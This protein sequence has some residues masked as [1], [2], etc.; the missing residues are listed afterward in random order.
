MKVFS[1]TIAAF[2]VL[3]SMVYAVPGQTQ[4]LVRLL[5]PTAFYTGPGLHFDIVGTLNPVNGNSVRVQQCQ[6]A[7][8]EVD[9]KLGHSLWVQRTDLLSHHY[10]HRT[11]PEVSVIIEVTPVDKP[12]VHKPGL[13]T[14][15]FYD[16]ASFKGSAICL[17]PGEKHPT[18]G[19]WANRASSVRVS[20]G[21][22]AL[23]CLD[24]DFKGACVEVDQNYST[25]SGDLENNVSSW[26]IN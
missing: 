16:H 20:G 19:K 25:F 11:V 13:G 6:L 26:K 23:I 21:A 18:L 14:V 1:K 8:C 3:F 10:K 7:W 17:T 15:C 12:V 24:E 2:L 5:K 4:E 9:T 22:T